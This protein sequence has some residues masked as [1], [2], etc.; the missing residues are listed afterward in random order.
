[1]THM[2]KIFQ[3]L[4]SRWKLVVGVL[5]VS[6]IIFFFWNRQRMKAA[7]PLTFVQPERGTLVK[8]LEVPGNITAKEYAKMRFAVGGK[9]TYVGAK[10]GDVVKKGKTIA[11]IDQAAL[12][13]DLERSLNT[14]E[15]ERLDWDQTLDDVQDRTLPE[16]EQRSKSK[17]QIDLENTV[18]GV[19]ATT[20]AI[21]NTVLSSP[22]NGVL[23]SSPAQFTGINLLAT[24]TFEIIN[25]STLLFQ[26]LVDEIDI[27]TIG[28]NQ[29]VAITL[30]AYEDETINS[31]I[32]FISYKSYASETGTAF[33]IEIPI[34]STDVN[35]F[36]I[37]L[38][39]DA[40]IEVGRKE[41]VLSIPL[42]SIIERDDKTYVQVK[43]SDTT[44]EEREI[45]TGL[46]TDDR[47]EVTSGLSEGD[48]VVL[49]E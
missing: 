20:I 38:N 32:S 21:N 33:L 49:P 25:P 22:F 11:T 28:L 10:E 30:D 45:S 31:Q 15:Q 1:M 29:P 13:K 19:Q 35:H 42:D 40:T 2:K 3:S 46:E 14:Y 27:H 6:A 12:R 36:R 16:S 23:I 34:Q 41:N 39:G 9:L 18:I 26:A 37:G 17:S 5:I 4:R 43:T 47:I 44:S 48:S 24:D 8:T 7:T